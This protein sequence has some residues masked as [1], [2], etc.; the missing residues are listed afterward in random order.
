M[1]VDSRP[2]LARQAPRILA[3]AYLGISG[4][5]VV[6]AFAAGVV[7]YILTTPKET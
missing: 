5:A 4:A 7:A 3:I 6:G 2:L 1:G